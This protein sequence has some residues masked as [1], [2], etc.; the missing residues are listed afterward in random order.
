MTDHRLSTRIMRSRRAVFGVAVLGTLALVAIF[1]DVFAREAPIARSS[2]H[3][4][5]L[6]PENAASPPDA[7][8]ELR[9][10]IRYGPS[11]IASTPFTKPSLSH[12]L[13]TDRDGRDVLA[14]LVHG[15]RIAVG[16][17][18]VV[19]LLGVLGGGIAGAFASQYTRRLGPTL[20]RVAQAVDAFPALIVVAL[21]RAMEGSSTVSVVV[22]ATIVQ[23]ASVARLVRTE[24]HRLGAEDFVLAAR[25]LGATKT[26]ILVRH[27]LPHLGPSLVS[28]AALGLSAVVMLEATLSFLGLGP[29]VGGASWG[30]MLAEGAR[31]P[32]QTPL[33]VVPAVA[34]S[35]TIGAAYLFAEGLREA[36]DPV[37]L[38][39]R[40]SS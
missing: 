13:G 32:D 9:A 25:A 19:A 18:F 40:D 37:T 21:F 15:A 23:W 8:F 34:L 17:G 22:G 33:F 35:L 30:E 24:L 5:E 39:V 31:H 14:R 11:T 16:A 2:A 38:R 7:G 29:P 4:F 36:V 3:G 12:P 6:L 1:A 10:P 20:E 28:S 26:R 27:L